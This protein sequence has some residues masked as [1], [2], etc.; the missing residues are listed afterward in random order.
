MS[1]SLAFVGIETSKI[2]DQQIEF[3]SL[4]L[5]QNLEQ[6]TMP[7]SISEKGYSPRSYVF[8]TLYMWVDELEIQHVEIFVYI[9]HYHFFNTTL[10]MI[11]H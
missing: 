10:A 2:H 4:T 9:L 5:I 3:D 1:N 11:L 8:N 6:Q 7:K